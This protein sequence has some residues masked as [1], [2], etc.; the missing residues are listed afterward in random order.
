MTE[1]TVRIP[2]PLR[3][4]TNQQAEV[5]VHGSTVGQALADLCARHEG[6][7]PRIFTADGELRRFVNVFV[8]EHHVSVLEGLATPVADGDVIAIIPAVAG[9]SAR[10]DRLAALRRDIVEL[11]PQAA[12][13]RMQRGAVLVDVREQDEIA[14]GSPAGALHLGRGFLELRIEDAVPELDRPVMTL[15]GGGAR[16]LFAAED[17]RRLGYSNVSS[18]AGGFN[19]WK[20]QGLPFEVPRMLDAAAR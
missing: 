6:V 4:F 2:T 19:R 3:P 9:G 7:G 10:D 12:W 1:V 8:G 13:D 18:V 11:E 17:L 5:A 14:A 20:D 16:S 15:C